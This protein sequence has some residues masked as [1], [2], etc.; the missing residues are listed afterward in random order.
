MKF[1]N[2]EAFLLFIPWALVL[3]W[4][5]TQGPKYRSRLFVPFSNWVDSRPRMSVPTPFRIFLVLRSIA[6]GLLIIALARPQDV[7]TKTKRNVDAVDMILSFDLSKSMDAVDFKPDR[8]TV[9]IKT[10]KDFIEKRESDRMGLVLFSGEAYLAVPLTLDHKILIEAI[11]KSS[12]RLLQD[13]TAIGQSLAVAT[14]HLRNSKAKSRIII[15][16]TDGDNNMGTVDPDT[17]AE[18]A[19]GYGLKIYTV[20]IGK[21]GRVQFPVQRVDPFSGRTVTEYQDLYDA[22]NEELL[23]DIAQKTGG[24]F[25]RAGSAN[26]LEDIFEKIDELEKSEVQYETLVKYREKAWPWIVSGLLLLILE[27][28]LLNTRW[29][30]VP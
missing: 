15:L 19:K 20:G 27:G 30:K 21:K 13:G 22:V 9:A 16:V 23:Q 7:L 29:R 6:L 11:E 8:R 25:F 26:V 12:N 14:H 1:A 5:Y 4:T 3:Y 24:K 17:A 2:P 10:L 28:L 18:L